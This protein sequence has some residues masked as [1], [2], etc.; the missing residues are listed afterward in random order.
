MCGPFGKVGEQVS[1]EEAYDI[2][3]NIALGLMRK[4]ACLLG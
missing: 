3:A 1:A 2:A 4:P